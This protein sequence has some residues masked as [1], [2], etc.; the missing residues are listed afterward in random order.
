MAAATVV[1]YDS[2][3][4]KG[5]PRS[6]ADFFDVERFPG[7]RGLRRT[8][9]TNLEWALIA[10]GVSHEK[11]YEVLATREGVDRAFR[12]MD[13]IKPHIEWW[14]LGEEAVRLLETGRVVMTSA[15]NGRIYSAAQR[16]ESFEI[17]WDQHVR[18]RDVLAIVKHTEHLEAAL[19]LVYF[20]S[21]SSS[22]ANQ[23]MQI[24]YGPLRRSSLERLPDEIRSHL[25]TAE[26]QFG[27]GFDS[28]PVWWGEHLSE[29]RTRFERWAD[30]PVM[31]PKDWPG[32]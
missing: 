8:P 15:Y 23:A 22:L 9:R 3:A 13:R 10:D 1:A 16:G 30:R 14:S 27:Q 6:I 21:S 11:V 19:R 4:L 25:P 32:R 17:L 7:P 12:V 2:K 20:A 5:K 31:V 24:P 28:D 29:L 18:F 26:P